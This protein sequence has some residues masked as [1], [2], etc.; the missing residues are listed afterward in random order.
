MLRGKTFLLLVLAAGCGLAASVAVLMYL[1]NAQAQ[2]VQATQQTPTRTVVVAAADLPPAETLL[3]RHLKKA[4]WPADLI[5]AGATDEISV[6]EGRITRTRIASG[7]PVLPMQ[8][9]PKGSS[10]GL[11]ALVPKGMRAMTLRVNETVGVAGFI[12]TGNRVDIVLTVEKE[13]SDAVVTKTI[14]QHIQVAAVGQSYD[15]SSESSK[16]V[17]SVTLLVTPEESEKLALAIDQGRIVLALRNDTDNNQR[18]AS[19]VDFSGLI[20]RPHR[21]PDLTSATVKEELPEPER[22]T[23][24]DQAPPQHH[25]LVMRGREKQE[26]YFPK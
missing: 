7:Q 4:S 16:V 5:P 15:E 3:S 24:E 22:V 1:N 21:E 20:P 10:G 17:R 25:V 26:V 23:I 18:I 19:G 8:L 14:L 2:A 6:L 11:S 12:R 13:E 9:A